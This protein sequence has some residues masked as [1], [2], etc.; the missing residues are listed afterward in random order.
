VE[1]LGSVAV[2]CNRREVLVAAVVV[3]EAKAVAVGLVGEAAGL[4]V[5]VVTAGSVVVRE[6]WD[7]AVGAMVEVLGVVG[8]AEERAAKGSVVAEAVLGSEAVETG[9]AAEA[10]AASCVLHHRTCTLCR[11]R[12][13]PCGCS[14]L[15]IPMSCT[16]CQFA[17]RAS[18]T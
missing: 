18:A 17:H 2:G 8:S 12:N 13:Q 6:G 7:L 16:V 1:R 14:E 10:A 11:S 3:K 4:V 9:S 5:T 15:R